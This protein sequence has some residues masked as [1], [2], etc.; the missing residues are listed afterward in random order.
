[1][2]RR[3]VSIAILLLLLVSIGFNLH[4][5]T[6]G[7]SGEKT[8]LEQGSKQLYTCGMHPQIIQEGPGTCPICGMNLV[9]LSG[10]STTTPTAGERKIAYWVAPMDPNYISDKPGKSPMGMDLVPVYEDELSSGV[11]KIDPVTQQNVGVT[12]ASV[13]R[14]DL[15]VRLRTNGIV[16][17]PENAEYRVNPKVSGWIDKLYVSRTGDVVKKGQPLL[18]IYSPEL[19]SAQEEYLLALRS[20]QSL[21]ASGIER[22]SSGANDLLAS[23]RRRLELWDVS[24]DQIQE[25]EKTREVRRTLALHS[26]ANGV[27]LQKNAVEGTAINAGM[28]LFAIADLDPIW[29]EAQIFEGE[30]PLVRVGDKV[31]VASPYD[32]ML[33]LQGQVDYIY[34]YLDMK[35]RTANVRIVLSNPNL[36]LRPDMYVDARIITWPHK[37]ALAI[38]KSSVIR[39]GE[40]DVVFV[41]MGEGKFLPREVTLGIEADPYYEV[42]DGLA[43]GTQIV[44]SGQF[45]LDSEAKLQEA[46]QRRLQQQRLSTET[47]TSPRQDSEAQ[48]KMPVHSH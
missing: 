6:R 14:R 21:G 42:L 30:L 38:L 23:A 9:P 22:V 7:P 10:S 13:E 37:D 25:L 1:M 46:I 45:L 35:T 8:Q 29:V 48:E 15:S 39:S 5:I 16:K 26:P 3:S 47:G 44:T 33:T 2:N 43:Q 17:Y 32:P 4:L 34:P 28:D 19:V 27:V 20:A 12:T 31:E 41:A 24:D 40:R 11:I 18:D 36:E